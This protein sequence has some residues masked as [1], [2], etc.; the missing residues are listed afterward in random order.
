MA[1]LNLF[2]QNS[3]WIL[4]LKPYYLK[5]HLEILKRENI[6][7]INGKALS[8]KQA[9][10]ANSIPVLLYHGIL[11]KTDGDNITLNE[12]SDQMF[13]LKKAGYETVT[14]DE[15]TSFMRG[16]KQLSEKSFVLTFDDGNKNS[17]YPADPIL[18]KLDYE[19][20]IFIISDHSIKNP[21]NFH[22][23]VKELKVMDKSK[24]W[25]IQA[26]TQN[27]HSEPL[28]DKSGK[29]GHFF[30]DLLWLDNK[31]RLET[32]SEFEKRVVSDMQT[33]K[34]DIEKEFDK[35][36]DY[37]TFPFGD[38]GQES[39][40]FPDSEEILL[41]RSREIYSYTLSQA[42]LKEGS[43]LNCPSTDPFMIKRIIVKPG[44][45][46]ESL[47]KVFEEVQKTPCDQNFVLPDHIL[48]SSI[49]KSDNLSSL[50]F[51][52]FKNSILE[53]TSRFLWTKL[54]Q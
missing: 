51:Q 43:P 46:G 6:N 30:S 49:K 35:K 44:W 53:E 52:Y 15:L 28:I 34:K 32:P 22:L 37:F 20:A 26:H 47:V 11:D 16:E 7:S 4:S 21:Y 17:F 25:D 40:N 1:G 29:T 38:Y 50:N 27:G 54:I 39:K 18:K 13:K 36:V 2:D 3:Y 31:D 9:K 41:R 12:F 45:R 8:S 48:E 33:V 23:S 14:L 42:D 10:T 24:R 19:A 5:T